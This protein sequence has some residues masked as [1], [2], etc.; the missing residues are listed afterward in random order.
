MEIVVFVSEHSCPFYIVC[1]FH[2]ACYAC[3]TFILSASGWGLRI[4]EEN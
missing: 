1:Y 2:R 4:E 3:Y